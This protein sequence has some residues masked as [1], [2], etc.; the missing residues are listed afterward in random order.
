[1]NN[2]QQHILTHGIMAVVFAVILICACILLWKHR[3]KV[4]VVQ[5]IVYIF[6]CVL[7]LA[8]RLF[9]INSYIY[10][11]P[12]T[13]AAF[14]MVKMIDVEQELL[15]VVTVVLIVIFAF[16]HNRKKAQGDNPDVT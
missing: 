12:N 9:L 4:G 1:M 3:K 5:A 16:S 8:D 13:E 15:Y 2:L 14:N 7:H 10:I 6:M 11:R